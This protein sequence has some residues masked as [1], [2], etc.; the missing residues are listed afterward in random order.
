MTNNCRTTLQA[1]PAVA[2]GTEL[3]T[4]I[5]YAEVRIVADLRLQGITKGVKFTA[6]TTR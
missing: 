6:V 4:G 2:C 5:S 1:P 3:R